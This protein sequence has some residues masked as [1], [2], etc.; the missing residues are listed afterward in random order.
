[1]AGGGARMMVG[2]GIL[3]LCDILMQTAVAEICQEW[4]KFLRR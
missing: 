3:W 4:V 1:M 2:A